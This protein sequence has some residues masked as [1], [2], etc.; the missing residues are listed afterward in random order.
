[1]FRDR[2]CGLFNIKPKENLLL[3][4]LALKATPPLHLNALVLVFKRFLV[5]PG[6][7]HASGMS[8]L[9]LKE[10]SKNRGSARICDIME[11]LER[12][13]EPLL[14]KIMKF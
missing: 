5:S 13:H 6:L 4:N 12:G 8:S 10:G 1:M 7:S 2:G 9:I 3:G 11:D 14:N